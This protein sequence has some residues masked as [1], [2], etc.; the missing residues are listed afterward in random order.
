MKRADYLEF[1]RQACE[2]MI[3][4]TAAKNADYSGGSDVDDAFANF[5]AVELAGICS[6]EVGFL[7]RISD[8]M[9]RIQSFVKKG[10]LLV[11]DES[12]ED[13]LLDAANYMILLAG[14]IRDRRAKAQVT[15]GYKPTKEL[16]GAD[17][18]I[19]AAS[20]PPSSLF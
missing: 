7:T 12:V 14:F 9:A 15:I 5:R 13:T 18:V 11:K 4:I 16:P 17:S 2:K 10:T 1:H 6:A 19:E 3:A 8:K 20:N